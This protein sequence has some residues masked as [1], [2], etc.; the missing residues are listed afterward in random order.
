MQLFARLLFP[1]FFELLSTSSHLLWTV[2]VYIGWWQLKAPG[3]RTLAF[4]LMYSGDGDTMR[5]EVSHDQACDWGGTR[6]SSWLG[7]YDPGIHLSSLGRL[8]IARESARRKFR[9]SEVF[10][11]QLIN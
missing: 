8:I 1:L 3:A 7:V 2:H 10:F 11:P 9:P 5:N 4:G 6:V